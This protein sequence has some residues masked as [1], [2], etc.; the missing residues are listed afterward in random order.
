MTLRDFD[1]YR[2]EGNYLVQNWVS[3]DLVDLFLQMG[4]DLFAQLQIQIEERKQSGE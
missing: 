3:I 1:W 2:R 4:V